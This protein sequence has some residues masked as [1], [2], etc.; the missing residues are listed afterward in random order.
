MILLLPPSELKRDG[1]DGSRVLDFDELSFPEL[2]LH[3]ARVLDALSSVSRSVEHANAALKLGPQQQF[4]IER[5][6]SIRSS[7]VMPA[8][9]RYTG[10]LYD[11]LRADSLSYQAR[12]FAGRS[13][14]VQSALFGLIGADDPIP[15]YRLSHD[16]RLPGL[17]LKAHWRDAAASALASTQR[18]VI[19]LRSEAYAALG[20]RPE[21]SIYIRVVSETADGR[22]VAASHFNKKAK[23]EFTHAVLSARIVHDCAASL[24][25][26][27]QDHGIRLEPGVTAGELELFVKAEAASVRQQRLK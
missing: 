6:R 12:Q 11:A 10:V 8:L 19:D 23:G 16:S 1:G 21:S 18:F 17:G 13:L 22:R 24:V 14:V 15:A 7:P 26:W 3:R 2:S 20:P 4:E 5:N 9:D 25:E 27:A